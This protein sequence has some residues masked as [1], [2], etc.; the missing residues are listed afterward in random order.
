VGEPVSAFAGAEKATS[1]AHSR[2]GS[3]RSHPR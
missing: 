3:S 1:R 2:S